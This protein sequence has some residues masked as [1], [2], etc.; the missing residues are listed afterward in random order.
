MPTQAAE[1]S[2]IAKDFHDA[3]NMTPA[4]LKKWL[5]SEDSKKVGWNDAGKKTDTS[6]H[7]SVGH[8]MGRHI[9]E[10]KA[11]KAADLTAADYAHMQKVI[12]YVHRHL[13]QHP[14]GG[15][16]KIEHSRW[17]HSLMNWGHDPLKS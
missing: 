17:R 9:L 1:H 15:K 11:K 2:Q 4:T 3:V 10:I 8:E 5:E 16:D 14:G 12:G 13:K 6:G 7:E